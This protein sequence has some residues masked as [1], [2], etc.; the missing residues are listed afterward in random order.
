VKTNDPRLKAWPC[1]ESFRAALQLRFA[2]NDKVTGLN[3]TELHRELDLTAKKTG[4]TPT[5]FHVS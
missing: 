1:P 2:Q 3:R 4:G 5:V